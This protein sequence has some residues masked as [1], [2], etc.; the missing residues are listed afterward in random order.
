MQAMIMTT[1]E[2]TV[3]VCG[4]GE[5]ASA[6]TRRLASEGYAVAI[7][8]ESPPKTLRRR[9]SFSDAWFDV[10]ASLDGFT[11]RRADTSSEFLLGLQSRR[12]IPVL[13]QRFSDV[14][15]RWPWNV[16]VATAEEE[17]PPLGPLLDLAELTIGI[18]ADF[19]AGRDCHLVIQTEGPDP[20]A[21]IRHGTTS[22]FPET[23]REETRKVLADFSGVFRANQTIGSAVE[24]GDTLGFINSFPIAAPIAGR[25]KGMARKG[26]AVRAGAPLAE[27]CA[28]GGG[29]VAGVD[30]RSSLISR[31]VAFAIEAELE[32]WAPLSFENWR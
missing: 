30:D 12:F 18:G 24:A 19:V 20:G 13:T 26:L 14:A 21:I 32:G 22:R 23:S 1:H 7:H 25:I 28:S 29:R 3:L 31:G 17:E 9:M 5:R 10:Q 16:I 27:L 8:Q 11:A 15:G 2:K 6:V 4:I